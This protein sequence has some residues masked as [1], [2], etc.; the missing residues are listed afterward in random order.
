MTIHF[1]ECS[2]HGWIY[3]CSRGPA[4]QSRI[5]RDKEKVTCFDCLKIL[6]EWKK[7]NKESE[8]Q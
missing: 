2:T 3:L 4:H 8:N 1:T 7:E 5:T 6:K